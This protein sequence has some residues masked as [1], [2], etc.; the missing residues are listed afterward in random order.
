M[1]CHHCLRRFLPVYLFTAFLFVL[2]SHC[3]GKSTGP[4]ANQSYFFSDTTVKKNDPNAMF[5]EYAYT[6][7]L[8]GKNLQDLFLY[9]RR[10][11]MFKLKFTKIAADQWAL[12]AY[13]TDKKGKRT[14][15]SKD[16]PLTIVPAGLRSEYNPATDTY[17]QIITR[18]DMKSF[19]DLKTLFGKNKRIPNEE[20]E[21]KDVHLT[22]CRDA[23][24]NTKIRYYMTYPGSAPTTC[25]PV[26]ILAAGE[27]VSN[28]SPPGSPCM[29]NCDEAPIPLTSKEK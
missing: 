15:H 26:K 27:I 20:M 23:A 28:P 5:V 24:G 3:E 10:H 14:R 7:S 6:V 8:T 21:G 13:V 4:L 12:T 17:E 25:P 29:E 22:P 11:K 2:T 18:G 1:L 9:K 19:L 16:I